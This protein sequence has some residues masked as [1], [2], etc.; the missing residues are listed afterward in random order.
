MMTPDLL[1][2]PRS[3]RIIANRQ[4]QHTKEVFNG[5]PFL[6]EREAHDDSFMV[7]ACWPGTT[8]GITDLLLLCLVRIN[9]ASPSKKNPRT[10]NDPTS[11]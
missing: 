6:S 5:Y 2:I 8:K 3:W 11:I 9:A 7:H 1:E 10:R 4:S